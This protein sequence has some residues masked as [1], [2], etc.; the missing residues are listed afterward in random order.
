MDSEFID[1]PKFRSTR[2]RSKFLIKLK[3]QTANFEQ[4]L[5]EIARKIIVE[6]QQYSISKGYTPYKIGFALTSENLQDPMTITFRKKEELTAE[7]I[8]AKFS[9]FQQSATTAN[10]LGAPFYVELTSIC[11]IIGGCNSLEEAVFNQQNGIF[12][13]YST[14]GLCLFRS[15]AVGLAKIFPAHNRMRDA[16]YIAQGKS[17]KNILQKILTGCYVRRNQTYPIDKYA[18]IIENFLNNEWKDHAPF[19]LI[20]VSSQNIEDEWLFP[21]REHEY[22]TLPKTNIVLFYENNHF[23]TV[24]EPN[25]FFTTRNICFECRYSIN[26]ME[27]HSVQCK[28]KCTLCNRQQNVAPC[29]KDGTY[30][31]CSNCHVS[32]F[33]NECYEQHKLSACK[34]FQKCDC[35]GVK[36]KKSTEHKCGWKWQVFKKKFSNYIF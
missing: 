15:V 19:R 13:N 12:Q 3:D 21:P 14:D 32:F 24:W 11:D 9:K 25:T 8:V 16:T 26:R 4:V 20:V 7:N 6:S 29:P 1:N 28:R 5:L 17:Q 18:V 22:S 2:T 30:I 31:K 10:L 33:N 34:L 36:H 27:N 35:C 23:S